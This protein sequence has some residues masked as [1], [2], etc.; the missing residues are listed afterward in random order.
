MEVLF[1]DAVCIQ[2]GAEKLFIPLVSHS[3]EHHVSHE[4]LLFKIRIV[5]LHMSRYGR[6]LHVSDFANFQFP[7][8]SAICEEPR[9]KNEGYKHYKVAQIL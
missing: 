5:T 6:K 9:K 2:S 8:L 1:T 7:S 3:H 4:H